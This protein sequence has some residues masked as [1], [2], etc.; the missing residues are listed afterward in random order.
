MEGIWLDIAEK[1]NLPD[2]WV[3][4]TGYTA[5]SYRMAVA[6]VVYRVA[7]AAVVYGVAYRNI[8]L[9]VHRRL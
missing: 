4:G 2:G 9:T 3:R 8:D 1:V 5:R 6:A 7:V